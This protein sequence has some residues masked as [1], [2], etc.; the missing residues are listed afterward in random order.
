[1]RV[2]VLVWALAVQIVLGGVLLWQASTGFDLFRSGDG[3]HGPARRAVVPPV[4]TP[5]VDRFDAD[6]AWATAERQVALGPRPAGSDAQRRAAVFLRAGLPHGRFVAIGGGLRNIA[7]SLPGRGRPVLLVAH[8]DT[9]PVAG[10]VGANNS[11]TGVGAVLEIARD[12]RRLGSP[13]GAAPVDF[14]LTDGEEAPEYPVKGNFYAEGLR[15]SRFAARTANAK[16]VIVLDFI[17]NRDIRLQHEPG[18]DAGLW[19]KLRAA[20]RQVGTLAVFPGGDQGRVLDDHTPFVSAGLTA[21]D[22]IDF[23]YPCWQKPCDRMSNIAKRSLDA[24][25]ETVLQLVRTLR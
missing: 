25:G 12:L 16:A 6:R 15:G 23:D 1:M 19:A 11:A 13:A 7:G 20:A 9:T 3:H 17:A 18:S 14:L 10:Y 2:R 24:V 5:S 8:Y 4:P 21:I 22:L